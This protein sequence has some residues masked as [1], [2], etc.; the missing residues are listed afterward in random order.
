MFE[1]LTNPLTTASSLGV[2]LRYIG[3]IVSSIV[4]ILAIM[5]WLTP[6]QVAEITRKVEAISGQVPGLV[7]AVSGLIAMLIPLYAI[8]TKSSSDKAAEA[9]KQI[10]KQIPPS[11]PVEI[12]TPGAAPNIVV[13]PKTS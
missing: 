1:K 9:A 13:P 11:A 10:D 12:V 2:A 5:G 3:T 4:A 7:A 6:D 8:L